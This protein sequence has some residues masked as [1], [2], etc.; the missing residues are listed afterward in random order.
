MAEGS[1]HLAETKAGAGML[2]GA[3]LSPAPQE[4]SPTHHPSPNFH[5]LYREQKSV[6]A[7]G[8]QDCLH[9]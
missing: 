7:Q 5:T 3:A 8:F 9:K 4:V 6:L 2:R 1:G